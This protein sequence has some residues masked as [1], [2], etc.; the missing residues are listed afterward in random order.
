[1]KQPTKIP[2]WRTFLN[3]IIAVLIG[4]FIWPL[5]ALP[6]TGGPDD[7]EEAGALM[8]ISAAISGMTSFPTILLMTLANWILNKQQLERK[9]YQLIHF[10]IHLF[11][12]MLTFFVLYVFADHLSKTE[13][14][15]FLL[16]AFSYTLAGVCTWAVTFAIYRRKA[17]APSPYSDDILDETI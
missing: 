13:A 1:M 15:Q 6:F 7:L 10:A 14:F 8:L 12:A 11:L 2:V 3:W 9:A 16:I 5:L 17:Q 4:S